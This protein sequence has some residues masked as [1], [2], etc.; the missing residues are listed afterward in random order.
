MKVSMIATVLNEEDTIKDFMKSVLNQVKKPDEFIVVDGGS[1]DNTFEILKKYS[2]KHKWIK[3]FQVKG[4]S[5]GRGRNFAIDK[6]KNEIIA[7]TDAGCILDKGW[8][9]NITKPFGKKGVDVSVGIYK[10]L[11]KNDFEYFQGQIAVPKMGKIDTPSRMSTRSLAFKKNAWKNV[12]GFPDLVTGED[13]LFHL[14]LKKAGFRYEFMKDAIVHWR[15]RKSWKAFAKQFYK[16]GVG[17]RKSGNIFKMKI[18][19]LVF[20]GFW[21]LILAIVYSAFTNFIILVFL[22]GI[23]FLYF[24]GK[25]VEI[26]MRTK[27]MSALFYATTLFF[28]KRI[29]YFLGVSIG[30]YF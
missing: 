17:D 10:P 21:F 23:S 20:L 1:S 29:C 26:F 22:L 4:A 11:Y 24:L 6:S 15:M 5:I 18:N 13:T 14:N 19:F 2:I 7:C 9:R 8:L 27:K 16:Y 12:G 25:G 28:L 3:V 30:K